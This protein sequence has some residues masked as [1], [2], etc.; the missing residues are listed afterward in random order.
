MNTFAFATPTL[1]HT[2]GADRTAR[3]EHAASARRLVRRAAR[4]RTSRGRDPVRAASRPALVAS[5][6]TTGATRSTSTASSPLASLP[7]DRVA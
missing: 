2:F 1:A 5:T 4:E 6:A 3:Y 7:V